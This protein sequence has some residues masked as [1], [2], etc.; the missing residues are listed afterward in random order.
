MRLTTLAD[1][2]R[3]PETRRSDMIDMSRGMRT[4][5]LVM[6]AHVAYES[7]LELARLLAANF[8]PEVSGIVSQPFVLTA[9][10][11]GQRRKHVPD[12]LLTSDNG[13]IVGCV[14]ASGLDRYP[15]RELPLSRAAGSWRP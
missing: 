9:V 10:V 7:R 8:D 11:G 15:L 6:R 13:P 4:Y 14:Q 3:Q 5:R 2:V 1:A 12:Y